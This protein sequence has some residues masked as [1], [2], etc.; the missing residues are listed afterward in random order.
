MVGLPGARRLGRKVQTCEAHVKVLEEIAPILYFLVN[1]RR[2]RKREKDPALLATAAFREYAALTAEQA[3]TRLD[4]ERTRAEALDE[5][6]FKLTLSLAVGM[7]LLG[8]GLTVL[9]DKVPS[10]LGRLSC[11]GGSSWCGVVHRPRRV[12]G[13][14]PRGGRY[15]IR[16]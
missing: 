16:P 15:S 4:E 1:A 13:T 10:P 12:S 11:R 9:L 6:T 2:L 7:T 8:T 5:K 14:P 3:D